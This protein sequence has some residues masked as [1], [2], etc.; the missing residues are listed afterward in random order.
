M[1]DFS[2]LNLPSYTP[3]DITE[4]T[5]KLINSI[6]EF[7]PIDV[8]LI[9]EKHG[10][11]LVP[12]PDLKFLSS[13]DAF[14]APTLKQIAY[15]PNI[16]PPQRIRFS[17]AHELGH[18]ILHYDVIKKIR[19]KDYTEWKDFIQSIPDWFWGK[20][21]RHANDFAG[22]LLVPRHLLLIEL[23]KYSDKL[24][25]AREA[26]G[27]DVDSVIEFLSGP[28]ARKFDVSAGVIKV[29]FSVENINPF[30]II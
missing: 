14:Y 29:R 30:D 26:I 1:I 12:T 8:D 24:E 3:S 23:E 28:L 5:L 13:T 7:L 6:G 20:I 27:E 15:D 10:L 19:F 21:E 18:H 22:K 4:I 2:E 25:M 9:A 11:D 16:Y 17:I